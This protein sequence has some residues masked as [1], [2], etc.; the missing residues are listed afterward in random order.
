MLP[1]DLLGSGD[2]VQISNIDDNWSYTLKYSPYKGNS[3][4][5]SSDWGL[6]VD[7]GAHNEE[8]SV[9]KDKNGNVSQSEAWCSTSAASWPTA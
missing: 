8:I 6:T 7:A 1:S 5:T 3:N 2:D 4:F 9:I